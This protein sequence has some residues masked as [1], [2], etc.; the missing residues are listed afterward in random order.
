MNIINIFLKYNNDNKTY[1]NNIN[2]LLLNLEQLK[3][4]NNV[5]NKLK[6]KIEEILYQEKNLFNFEQNSNTK[7]NGKNYPYFATKYLNLSNFNNI[8]EEYIINIYYIPKHFDIEEEIIIENNNICNQCKILTY[9]NM[10]QEFYNQCNE[11]YSKQSYI[12]NSLN[13][14]KE[15]FEYF[16]LEKELLILKEILKLL[17]NLKFTKI[18]KNIYSDMIIGG[19]NY[20]LE[21]FNNNKEVIAQTIYLKDNKLLKFINSFLK[22]KFTDKFFKLLN[23]NKNHQNKIFKDILINYENIKRKTNFQK[24]KKFIP[25]ERLLLYLKENTNKELLKKNKKLFNLLDELLLNNIIYDNKYNYKKQ[26]IPIDKVWEKYCEK[27]LEDLHNKKL[28]EENIQVSKNFLNINELNLKKIS[29]PDFI[30]NDNIYDAKYKLLKNINFDNK[31]INK[32]CR[33]MLVFKKEKGFLIFVKEKKFN[34]FNTN[35]NKK[36]NITKNGK[37]KYYIYENDNNINDNNININCIELEFF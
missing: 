4:D 36:F 17:N 23:E 29:K 6:L 21:K 34:N 25:K 15:N 12:N 11:L 2:I 24:E 18:K 7:I 16:E 30:I 8:K 37:F 33:D 14:K 28:N 10:F 31:D 35:Q 9:K 3:L 19:I 22:A 27:F 26:T 1:K 13:I 32:L 20:E 5:L